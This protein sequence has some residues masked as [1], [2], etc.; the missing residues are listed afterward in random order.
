MNMCFVGLLY[1][2]VVVLFDGQVSDIDSQ[3]FRVPETE[4]GLARSLFTL[5]RDQTTFVWRSTELF[6]EDPLHVD[7]DTIL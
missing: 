6:L 5:G 4:V 2:L 3:T 7:T 1:F